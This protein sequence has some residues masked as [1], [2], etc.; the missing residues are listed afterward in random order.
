MIR[1]SKKY[2]DR[3][4]SGDLKFTMFASKK[5]FEKQSDIKSERGFQ[6]A[7]NKYQEM[8]TQESNQEET[9][10]LQSKSRIEE[11]KYQQYMQITKSNKKYLQDFM[12]V[13]EDDH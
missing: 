13:L 11:M 6:F 5:L 7:V 4:Y 12:S 8:R 10:T 9:E 3:K 2:E 1:A